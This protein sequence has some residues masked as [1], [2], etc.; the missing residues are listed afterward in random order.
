MSDDRNMPG[1]DLRELL[2][3]HALADLDPDE[4]AEL[5]RAVEDVD[6]RDA[7]ELEALVGGLTAHLAQADSEALPTDV[8]RSLEAAADRWQRER[9]GAGPR[10]HVESGGGADSGTSAS[11]APPAAPR[12][13]ASWWA[14]SGWA[15]AA[16]LGGLLLM[17]PAPPIPEPA[18]PP[19]V[20]ELRAALVAQQ[21]L[22]LG[23]SATEDPAGAN[24]TGDLVWSA[25]TQAGVMRFRGL[26]PNDPNQIRYQLWIFDA[27]RDDRY[28]VDGGLFD[29]PPG[30][31][32]VLVPIDARLRIGQPVLF[33]VTIE[34]PQGVV[35][36]DRD[37]IVVVAQP[38][39]DTQAGQG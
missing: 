21:H 29:V 13:S 30:V 11:S 7:Q 26:E 9:S 20:A 5:A 15:V 8:R 32:E 34:P 10:L 3:G 12:S 22:E 25:Q 39:E 28:P 33:A 4:G 18:A 14:W 19:T 17:R 27:T 36:S 31:D 2:A 16:V 38:S 6:G 1:D 35:V 24:A 23:W 37:R